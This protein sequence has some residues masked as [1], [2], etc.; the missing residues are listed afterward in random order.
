MVKY[1]KKGGGGIPKKKTCEIHFVFRIIFYRFLINY[2][3]NGTGTNTKVNLDLNSFKFNNNKYTN[4]L[5]ILS[6]KFTK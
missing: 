2:I 1:K 6:N 4:L 3:N 5:K